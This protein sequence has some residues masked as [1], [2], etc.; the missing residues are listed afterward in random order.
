MRKMWNNMLNVQKLSAKPAVKQKYFFFLQ[1]PS[2]ASP[3]FCISDAACGE[4]GHNIKKW[5]K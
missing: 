1:I 4:G 2:S 5:Q 3:D